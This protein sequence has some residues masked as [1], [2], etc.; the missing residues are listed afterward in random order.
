M[1]RRTSSVINSASRKLSASMEIGICT[2]AAE[3]GFSR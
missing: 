2:V 1:P 3:I